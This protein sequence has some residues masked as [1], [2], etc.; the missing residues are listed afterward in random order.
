MA[1]EKYENLVPLF[2]DFF[3]TQLSR[4]IIGREDFSGA[5]RFYHP[6]LVKLDD[7]TSDAAI[8]ACSTAAG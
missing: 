2:A 7:S 4:P 3:K 5:Y 1:E 6:I 8:M